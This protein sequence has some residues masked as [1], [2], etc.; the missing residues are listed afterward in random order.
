MIQE[1]DKGDMDTDTVAIGTLGTIGDTAKS[2]HGL[3]NRSDIKVVW[4]DG[5]SADNDY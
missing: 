1:F 2:A 5:K 4:R 3:K